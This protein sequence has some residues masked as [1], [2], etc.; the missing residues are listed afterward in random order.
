MVIEMSLDMCGLKPGVQSI[1]ISKLLSQAGNRSM[2]WSHC[3][4]ESHKRPADTLHGRFMQ[5]TFGETHHAFSPS[6]KRLGKKPSWPPSP[7]VVTDFSLKH[8]SFESTN[9]CI[10]LS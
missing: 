5:P 1:I 2:G 10:I 8:V 9:C 7:S 6:R 3:N 4:L